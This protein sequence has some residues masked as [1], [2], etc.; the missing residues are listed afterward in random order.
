MAMTNTEQNTLFQAI[1]STGQIVMLQTDNP[2][3][4]VNQ[5][6]L[7]RLVPVQTMTPAQVT[8]FATIYSV[9]IASA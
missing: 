7:C 8:A 3:N 4:A 6:V 9:T 1:K 5:Y 2:T